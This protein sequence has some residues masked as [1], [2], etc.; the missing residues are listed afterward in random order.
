MYCRECFRSN[1][2]G[3]QY[4]RPSFME[5]KP[6]FSSAPRSSTSTTDE[7]VRELKALNK[8]MDQLL[9]ALSGF[10]VVEEDE[11]DENRDEEMG[12]VSFTDEE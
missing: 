10:E 6:P 1:D 2:S 9:E 7:V 12:D 11:E 8:K 5:K 4:K 3:S